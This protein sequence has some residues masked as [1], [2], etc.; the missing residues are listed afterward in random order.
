MPGKVLLNIFARCKI[1]RRLLWISLFY[2]HY[3]NYGIL[4]IPASVIMYPASSDS[5]HFLGHAWV[6]LLHMVSSDT[7][8]F[9]SPL[10]FGILYETSK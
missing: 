6:T 5:L 7:W 4:F 9:I 3:N 10:L 8:S 1:R 2:I